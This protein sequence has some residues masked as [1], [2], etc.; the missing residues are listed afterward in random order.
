MDSSITRQYGGTG[1]GLAISKQL[2]EIMGGNIGVTSVA[3]KGS[4]FWFTVRLNRMHAGEPPHPAPTIARSQPAGFLNLFA[5]RHA[6]VLIAEDNIT[7]QQVAMNILKRMGLH[8]DAVA[9]GAEVLRALES[10]PYD[11]V[12][13]DVQMPEMDGFA[14]TRLIRRL[15]ESSGIR[16]IPIIAMTA[17]AIRDAPENCLAAGMDDF[18][19]KPVSP[20]SLAA[21][22]KKW[23]PATGATCDS[24]VLPALRFSSQPS[25]TP[26]TAPVP[27]H[28]PS[29][30][31]AING[32]S[33]VPVFDRSAMMTRLM[34]DETLCRKITRDFLL[35]IPERIAKLKDCLAAADA[36]GAVFHAHTIKGASASV[37]GNRLRQVAL[38]IEHAARAADIRAAAEQ[39]SV[40]EAC[41]L[42]LKQAMTVEP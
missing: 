17:H 10:L 20:H 41:F 39:M 4:E 1:L 26:P 30:S 23:L 24:A 6:R 33:L 40:L 19:S 27:P 13:M 5:D 9:N 31:S 21:I 42:D 14:A 12:M 7:N 15:G 34:G 2:T 3:D 29:L 37:G 38:D 32:I 35:D 25:A 22:L 8:V 36:T 18:L 28:D 11:L 16:H